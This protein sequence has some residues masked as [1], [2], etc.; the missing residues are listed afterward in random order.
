MKIQIKPGV[1]IL[2]LNAPL[3]H[4]AYTA[5]DIWKRRG[6]IPT[7]TS[8]AEGHHMAGSLHPLGLAWDLR[9]R[10][11]TDPA[12]VAQELREMLNL[13]EHDF[14][15]VYG[16]S[17]HLDHIHVEYDPKQKDPK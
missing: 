7:I 14:D 4:L 2:E 17:Q 1:V 13:K 16:D 6:L 15:I 12:I 9:V 3:F 10:D 11:L 5:Y 8:G